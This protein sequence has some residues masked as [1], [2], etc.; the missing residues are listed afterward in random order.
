VQVAVT[1][2]FSTFTL[3]F[4]TRS[5]LQQRNVEVVTE[6]TVKNKLSG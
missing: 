1:V 3:F 5:P 4:H 6:V 2:N